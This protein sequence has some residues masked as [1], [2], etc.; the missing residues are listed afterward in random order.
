[1]KLSRR[2]LAIIYQL[3]KEAQTDK[4]KPLAYKDDLITLEMLLSKELE[5]QRDF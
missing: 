5:K 2:L 4:N 1:M 3:C